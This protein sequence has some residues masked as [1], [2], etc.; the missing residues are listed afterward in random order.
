M[1][2]WCSKHTP[3]WNPISISGYHIREAGS[4]AVQELAFTFSNA[5]TY[6]DSAVKRGLPVD[7]F[8]G[9]LSFFFN[10][11]SDFFEEIAKFRAA[12]RIWTKIMKERFQAKDPRS[13]MLRFQSRWMTGDEKSSLGTVF[14]LMTLVVRSKEEFVFIGKQILMK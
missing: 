4:T 11:H 13:W 12:R 2:E 10:V 1:F 7:Q 8:A 3:K 9:Q 5:I 14:N 6:V